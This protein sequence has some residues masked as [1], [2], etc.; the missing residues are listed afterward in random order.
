MKELLIYINRVDGCVG[1]E[2]NSTFSASARVCMYT[3]LYNQ[4]EIEM[5]RQKSIQL[6]TEL[7]QEKNILRFSPYLSLLR[8]PML[9][10]ASETGADSNFF[11]ALQFHRSQARRGFIQL[12]AL[13]AS[14][15]CSIH[16][17]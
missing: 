4:L 2:L 17:S 5:F 13:E 1:L 16:I 8:L 15:V 12:R 10:G 6:E 11:S 7:Q 3:S 14:K 9:A